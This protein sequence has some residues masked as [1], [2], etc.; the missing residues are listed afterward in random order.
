MG[1]LPSA[2]FSDQFL[3]FQ[4][5]PTQQDPRDKSRHL[6]AAD[7]PALHA[8]IAC[9]GTS[10]GHAGVGDCEPRWAVG[11]SQPPLSLLGG[12]SVVSLFHSA[13]EKK[14][15]QTTLLASPVPADLLLTSCP[16]PTGCSSAKAEPTAQTDP[17]HAS[18]TPGQGLTP[19]VPELQQP[20]C[21]TGCS[22]AMHS[23]NIHAEHPHN[24]KVPPHNSKGFH[25][26]SAPKHALPTHTQRPPKCLAP[27]T[28]GKTLKGT[29]GSV[30]SGKS[31]DSLYLLFW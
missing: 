22:W 21:H 9:Q 28:A 29:V 31:P 10:W 30:T 1:T 16:L 27:W 4:G 13:L 23:W 7:G 3:F 18:R 25:V 24:S 14:W 11:S 8:S 6:C 5:S 19:G 20:L 2:L 12:F 17:L 15:A 26:P